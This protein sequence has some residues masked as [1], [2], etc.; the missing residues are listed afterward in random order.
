MDRRVP[1]QLAFD[2][3]PAE[4]FFPRRFFARRRQ[5]GRARPRR[6]LAALAGAHGRTGR[7]ARCGQ[8]PSRRDLGCAAA[9]AR[10]L[11]SAALEE[12]GV[13]AA[14]ATGALV[15]ERANVRIPAISTSAPCSICSIWR[16]SSRP[17]C[18]SPPA[19]PPPAGRSRFP[20]S[21][22]GCARSRSSTWRAPD[23]A[24]LRA[25]LVKLFADR[26]LEVDDGLIAYL[27]VAHRAQLCRRPGGRRRARPRGAAPPA[28]RH[29]RTGR[30]SPGR[31]LTHRRPRR[32]SV[33]VVAGRHAF[34]FRKKSQRS[35]PRFA[36][37]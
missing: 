15:I 23:D 4:N 2:L 13:P 25:V 34:K 18:S 33:S 9:G 3:D 16:G 7:A 37:F 28:P 8:E 29:P 5:R 27:M 36:Y 17:S 6:K 22:R 31:S 19:V 14:L 35:S 11:A 32:A 12:A 1:R 21:P 10:R 20:I 26:Q 24:M 30:R